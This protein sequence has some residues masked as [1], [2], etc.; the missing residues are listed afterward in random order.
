MFGLTWVVMHRIDERSLF[1]G[2]DAIERLRGLDAEIYLSLTGVDETIG[3]TIHARH[4]YALE[5]IVWNALFVDVLSIPKRD[6]DR[7]LDYSA[8][9]EVKALQPTDE[10]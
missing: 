7:V 2:P 6:G 5:D 9:H 1:Y 4:T 10:K 3:Q 8:F